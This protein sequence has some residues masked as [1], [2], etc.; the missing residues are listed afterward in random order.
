MKGVSI[1]LLAIIPFLA[2]GTVLLLGVQGYFLQS[3]YKLFQLIIPCAWRIKKDKA[4]VL[5]ILWPINEPLPL[6]RT[7]IQ[8]IVLAFVLS[9]IAIAAL[10]LLLPALQVDPTI[11]KSILD[12]R[13][14]ISPAGAVGIVLFISVFNSALEELHFR[15]WMDREL[16]RVYGSY[17]GITISAIA[18]GGMH[19]L[20]FAGTPLPKLIILLAV[21]GLSIAGTSWSI[22]MRKPGGIHAAWL[23]HALTDALLLGWGLQWLRYL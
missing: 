12:E 5:R 8:A 16:S 11:I 15:A 21:I 9:G 7:W 23:S 13:F 20:I 17:V 19:A 18:F 4:R 1:L 3:L 6:L 10:V 22:L 2:K 14:P